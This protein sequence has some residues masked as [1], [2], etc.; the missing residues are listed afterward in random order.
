MRRVSS[1]TETVLDEVATA[2]RIAEEKIPVPVMRPAPERWFDLVLIV[3]NSPSMGIWQQTVIELQ[4]LLERH[5]AFRDVQTWGLL[6]SGNG[7]ICLRSGVGVAARSRRLH[8]PNELVDPGNQ[9]LFLVVSDCVSSMWQDGTIT[10]ALAPWV[11]TGPLAIVQMLPERLWERTAL[12]LSAAVRFRALSPGVPNQKLIAEEL[13]VWDDDLILE[14]GLKVPVVTLEPEPLSDWS[15]MVVGVAN[16]TSPGFILESPEATELGQPNQPNVQ[17]EPAAMS[18]ERI[19]HRFLNTASS[20]ARKLAGLLAAAPVISLPIVRL[21]QKTMLEQLRQV[22]IAEVFLGGILKATSPIDAHTDPDYVQYDFIDPE[23]RSLLLDASPL[24]KS[25]QVV[26]EVSS[27]I[28]ERAGLSLHEFW[29]TL[30]DPTLAKTEATGQQV[31]PFARV[32]AQVLRRLGGDYVQMAE[33]MERQFEQEDVDATITPPHYERIVTP[34]GDPFLG[35]ESA[36]TSVAFSPDSRVIAS[37]SRDKTVRLWDL[38]GNPIGQPF[39]GHQDRISSIAFSPDGTVIASGSGDSTVRQWNFHGN[40]IGQF[41]HGHE[42]RVTSVAFSPDGR[43]IA[44]SSDDGTVR[45]WESYGNPIGQPFHGHTDSIYSVAFSPDGGVIVSGSDDRTVRLWDLQ[46]NPVGQPFHGHT[47]SI[48]SVAFSPDGTVIAS[49]SRDGTVRL[50]NLQGDPLCEPIRGHQGEVWTVTF[51]PDGRTVASGS[52]DTTIRLWSVQVN[53]DKFTSNLYALLIGVDHYLPNRLYKNLKGSVRDVNLVAD[54]LQQGLHMPAENILKLVA[55]SPED[56]ALYEASQEALPTY[57]NIVTAFQQI[58]EASKAGDQIYIHF[59]GQGGRATTIFPELKGEDGL[60]EALVPMDV[61]NEGRYLRDVELTT[62]LK[63]MTDKGLIVTIA[64]DSCHAGGMVKGDAEVRGVDSIDAT[65]SRSDSLVASHEELVANWRGLTQGQVDKGWIP[66]SGSYVLLAACKPTE[67]VFEYAVN[68]RERYGAFTYWLIDTLK[69]AGTNITYKQ[70]LDRVTAKIHSKFPQQTPVLI[71][72]GDQLFFGAD[73]ALPQYTVTVIKVDSAQSQVTLGS[74]T[75]HGLGRCKRFAIYPLN[76]TDFTDTH[77]QVA[78]VE[79]TNVSESHSTAKI[80]LPNEGG[81]EVKRSIEPGAPAIPIPASIVLTSRVC[82]I[83]REAGDEKYQ[84]PPQL[85]E[86]QKPAL[87]A[88]RQALA[89]TGWLVEVQGEQESDYQVAINRQGQY[90][91]WMGVP[92]ENLNP[93]LGI[94]EPH[95]PQGM[96]ER[97]VHLTKYQSV[98]AIDNPASELGNALELILLDQNKQLFADPINLTLKQDTVVYLRL[99]S[100]SQVALNVAVLD[101]EP[102]WEISQIPLQGMDAPFYQLAPQET[103]DTKLHFRL[104]EGKSYQQARET[105]KLLATRGSID[106]RQLTLP[107]LGETIERKLS[108]RE[109]R[110]NFMPNNDA[111]SKFLEAIATAVDT[112][113]QE[114]YIAHNS[115]STDDWATKQIQITI[116]E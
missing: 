107:A 101:L 1:H 83:E 21:L 92:L 81:I 32:T 63:R 85:I 72:A 111:L 93:P 13:A 110:R 12:G 60:D 114:I 47:D 71:G 70:L 2:E 14:T 43:V 34:I 76:T 9:R 84:L 91:I 75:I 100:L 18:A 104:P 7:Q 62:L 99:K 94:D 89:A 26:N 115:D 35:H 49:G 23:V 4:K 82:L 69:A 59:S 19:V 3:D 113:P 73:Q 67:F 112:T 22:H 44:S 105:V 109:L 29:A 57:E 46:G 6:M 53:D 98:Q 68:G 52:S 78:I 51:S 15:K 39:H 36:V 45:L 31:Q 24:S 66:E 40:P 95:A 97:L 54:Y 86:K 28:A 87:D 25:T 27:F 79:V 50:W 103:V 8:S 11:K 88:V 80:L 41:F 5:G 108:N 106:F 116:V 90:E 37:G 102:T 38:Q 48:Y 20:T 55:P 16:A 58:T 10:T 56:Q 42:A 96:I 30:E 61:G 65:V 33:R 64:L 74:G 77:G 17:Q